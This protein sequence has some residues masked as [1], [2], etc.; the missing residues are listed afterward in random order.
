GL[1]VVLADGT[2]LPMLNKMTK[3]NTGPDLKHLFIG[4]EGTLGIITRAVLRLQP[5]ATG[6]NTALVALDSFDDALRL[7]RHA[8]ES[9][10]GLVSA[11]ELMWASYYETA[12]AQDNIRAPLP[13]GHAFYALLDMQS[14]T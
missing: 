11:F 8:R 12:T 10:S 4:S 9:L 3:N 6:A 14:A 1:E 7:L 2:V 5:K 13:A